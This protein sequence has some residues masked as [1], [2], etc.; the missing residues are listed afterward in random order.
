MSKAFQITSSLFL[1]FLGLA[2]ALFSLSHPNSGNYAGGYFMGAFSL[3][4]LVSG[5]CLFKAKD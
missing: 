3:F 5:I 4:F 1:F 2:M